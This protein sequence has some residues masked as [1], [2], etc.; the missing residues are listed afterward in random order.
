MTARHDEAAQRAIVSI[1]ARSVDY[2]DDKAEALELAGVLD[3]ADALHLVDLKTD[4]PARRAAFEAMARTAARAGDENLAGLAF[5]LVTCEGSGPALLICGIDRLGELLVEEAE[6]LR[7]VD[8]RG[9]EGLA[10]P[11]ARRGACRIGDLLR[12]AGAVHAAYAETTDDT[13]DE[14]ASAQ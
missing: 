3:K 7:E 11:R 4:T 10:G 1:A 14:K 6:E 13:T 5:A 2:L 9:P 12:A 8:A